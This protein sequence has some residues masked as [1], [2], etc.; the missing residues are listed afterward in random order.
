MPVL[1]ADGCHI[2]T[3]EGV[4][5]V[6]G[7]KLHPIQQAMVDMHGSQCGFCTP[8]IIVNLY[9][10]LSNKPNVDHLEE[11]LDGN[12][13]R[14]TGYR[15]IWDA[16]RSL[17]TDGEDAVHGPCGL[18]CHEC[19][20]RDT[21]TQDCNVSSKVLVSSSKD[22]MKTYKD[23]FLADKD[24]IDQ[25]NKMFP[26]ELKNGSIELDKPLIVVDNTPFQ[27]GGTWFKTTSLLET[28]MLLHEYG[29]SPSGPCKIIVGNT[30]V[31]I[32]QKFKYKVY[33]R[34]ICPS[35]VIRELFDLEVKDSVLSIGSCCPLSTL[36]HFCGQLAE[37]GNGALKRTL[38]PVHDMLRWFASSQIRN[39][40]CLAG[41]IVTASPIS[42][43]N[44]MLVAMNASLVISCIGNENITIS[45]RKVSVKDFFLGYRKVDL[46]PTEMVERVEIPI[47][48][49]QFEY[50]HAF[51]QARRRE[52]DISVVTSGMRLRLAVRDD[53]F[54]VD[55]VVISF[56]GMAPTTM[57][58]TQ[59]MNALSG[60]EFSASTF[61]SASEV[62]LHELALPVE[63][64]GGQAAY[65]TTLAASFL[66]KFF[67]LT[68]E[69][70][71]SDLER[72]R[73]DSS[74]GC[75]IPSRLQDFTS[76]GDDDSS[77]IQN[78]LSECKPKFVGV[79]S[80]PV[81]KV[82][83]GLED[84]MYPVK[85]S[86][87]HALSEAG[88][89]GQAYSHA[90][91]ALHCTGEADYTD[92]IP[93]PPRTLHAALILSSQCGV[94]FKALNKSSALAI[95]GVKGIIDHN[96]LVA[97]GGCNSFGPIAH[98][99]MVFL[100]AGEQ[101]R[102]VNEVLGIAVAETLEAAELA[103]RSVEVL[104]GSSTSKKIIVS[105]DDALKAGSFY[106]FSRH[107]MTKGDPALLDE[108]KAT[109]DTKSA[110]RVGDIVKI[111]GEVRTGPQEHFYLEPNSSLVVPSESDTNLT[112]YCS[113]QAVNK[114]QMCCA[115]ATGLQAHKVVV[116]MKRMGGGF[117]G[118]ETRSVF[119]SAAAAVAART[120]NLPVR[121]TLSRSVDMKTTGQRHAFQSKYHASAEVTADGVKLRAVDM[122][123]Y[124][125]GG[126]AFDL[127]GP[128]LDRALFHCDGVY[129][130][131]NFRCGGV[132]CKT[133]Q[134]PHTAYRGFGGPQGMVI[135][136]HIMDHF[137]VVCRVSGDE[138]RRANMYKAGDLVPFGMTIG[139]QDSGA[140]H[141]PAMWD[142][143]Y[144]RLDVQSRRKRIDQFN[145]KNK[146]I[147]RGLAVVPTKFGIA[148]TAKYM[149]QV[150]IVYS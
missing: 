140:W 4:G 145:A 70:L 31:G 69:D 33:P 34:L 123:L 129:N 149:N 30:E 65:R 40:A 121:L 113:T 25:P 49:E 14:C 29:Q 9:T 137:A 32:E 46:K 87:A 73:A 86:Q 136:E 71:K 84:K 134:A 54:V 80:Y 106:E 99:E 82:V 95:P 118:K 92:D 147:K 141:V 17:C 146:W 77:G 98:D 133:A 6:R 75:D 51:K 131:P 56:G 16:A 96:D 125:N 85:E 109:P 148:F 94:V 61:K 126:H 138:I 36:Q 10:L 27:A 53:K 150:R 35:D 144:S 39:V 97:L 28:L 93:L 8:G 90:S 7:N 68:L 42:D 143:L 3:V 115:S 1:A 128:V 103:A 44:P 78:W 81:P 104:Y 142:R 5:T 37:S 112:I 50:L 11:H 135:A 24:W 19:P 15:P 48:Q 23:T 76:V 117:G 114:T 89:V 26:D 124:V 130:F 127:S 100:P 79:Q 63:V 52:D 107:G 139:E 43:M 83:S 110:P 111:S 72:I 21:C 13:C 101:V 2:T 57:M 116:R 38:L 22:K 67:L 132:V 41:N 119:A 55:E 60:A 47:L 108:L 66:W 20:E 122:E 105:I 59:T 18:P 12:L 88:A 91:G 120:L 102:T 58:A 45:R 62:L 74:S 64:P